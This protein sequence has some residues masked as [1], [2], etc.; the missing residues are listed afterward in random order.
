[1]NGNIFADVMC[2]KKIGRIRFISF[3]VTK[4]ATALIVYYHRVWCPGWQSME[5]M[6]VLKLV[7]NGTY[8]CLEYIPIYVIIEK[9]T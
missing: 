5:L 9:L 2:T 7:T 4:F 6:L 1:M 3:K 8:P